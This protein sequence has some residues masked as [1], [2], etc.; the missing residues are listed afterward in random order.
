VATLAA[1]SSAA[2]IQN[3]RIGLMIISLNSVAIRKVYGEQ[4]A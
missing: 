3:L 2:V 1:S 4:R